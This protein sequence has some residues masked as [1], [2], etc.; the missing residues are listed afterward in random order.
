L[1]LEAAGLQGRLVS[2]SKLVLLTGI[3]LMYILTNL[4]FHSGPIE[5]SQ[6]YLDRFA[7]TTMPCNVR[8]MLGLEHCFSHRLRHHQTVLIVQHSIL[9]RVRVGA[10]VRV[11]V[12]KFVRVRVGLSL[13]PSVS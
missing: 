11:R 1:G 10:V 3:A 6:Y 5:V 13:S 2:S 12:G 4:R 9:D 8:V 7:G